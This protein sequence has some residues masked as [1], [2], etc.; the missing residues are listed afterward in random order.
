MSTGRQN[1]GLSWL[2]GTG[3]LASQISKGNESDSCIYSYLHSFF[4]SV[5]QYSLV[6]KRKNF[7]ILIKPNSDSICQLVTVHL[8]DSYVSFLNHT[9][10]LYKA[11]LMCK[12]KKCLTVELFWALYEWIN[13]KH[14]GQCLVQSQWSINVSPYYKFSHMWIPPVLKCL[15]NSLSSRLWAE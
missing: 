7:E 2:V 1:R 6:I 8:W 13:V 4:Q 5:F 14:F 12:K 10:F 3:C 9:W 15:L 11:G